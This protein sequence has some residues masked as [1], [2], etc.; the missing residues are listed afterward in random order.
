MQTNEPK[1][2]DLVPVQLPDELLRGT[3][4]EVLDD[5][6]EV[7]VI[8]NLQ[9]PM[10]TRSHDYR[11]DSRIQCRRSTAMLAGIRWEAIK[12]V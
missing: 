12:K 2:G 8:L 4:E 3:I 10:M 6:D 9:A 1:V 7:V 5:T 11:K